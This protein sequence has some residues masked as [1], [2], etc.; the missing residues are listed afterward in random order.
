MST[1]KLMKDLLDVTKMVANR[2]WA[3]GSSGNTS[4]RIHGTED[5]LIKSSG[6]SM[7]WIKSKDFVK[8]NLA[9]KTLDG[10]NKPSKEVQFHLGIYSKRAEIEAVIHAHPPFATAWAIVGTQP[11]LVTDPGK[12]ILKHV[13]MVE[14]ATPGSI[15]LATMVTKA[16]EDK[17]VNTVLMKG[18]GVVTAGKSIF[19]AF[20]FMDWTEDAARA[21]LLTGYIEKLPLTTMSKV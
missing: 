11:Q 19:E 17:S 9:G 5:V 12:T 8:V 3:P 18:H 14:S 15:E 10:K 4:V 6:S 13:P 7:S 21:A 1:S 2:G 20:N 16:F